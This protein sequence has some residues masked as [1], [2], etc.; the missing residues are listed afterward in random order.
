M[1]RIAVGY[2]ICPSHYPIFGSKFT[3]LWQAT[4]EEAEQKELNKDLT[5]I[6]SLQS[7][8]RAASIAL[9]KVQHT[10][11]MQT[12]MKDKVQV[13]KRHGE[14]IEEM[15]FSKEPLSIPK[16]GKFSPNEYAPKA[17][18]V[19]TQPNGCH[20]QICLHSERGAS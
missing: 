8:A 12:S 7:S 14:K 20:D 3:R 19:Y 16:H 5:A 13:V 2:L 6:Q 9:S 1:I 18:Q 17:P 10:A 11:E 15:V 4:E